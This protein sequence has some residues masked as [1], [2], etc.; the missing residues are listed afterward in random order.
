MLYQF[1][2]RGHEVAQAILGSFI[3]GTARRGGRVLSVAPAPA[4]ARP[5]DRGRAREPARAQRAG[6][7]T[8]ATSA[9]CATSRT[10]TAR[11]SCR[12]PATSGRSTRRRRD[13][14]SRSSITAT[15]SRTHRTRAPSRSRSAATGRSPRNGFWSSLT[16]ATT[17]EAPDAVLHRGQR[18][19]HFGAGRH[20]DAGRRHREEPRELREPARAQRRRHGS[21]RKRAAARRGRRR[22]CAAARAPR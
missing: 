17:L 14:R 10:P 20:A 11:S 6:S 5:L 3:D 2:A 4:L 1:S 8:G 15:R 12:C 21:R 7:A 22:T 16:M 13:G 9:W 19:R 18:A